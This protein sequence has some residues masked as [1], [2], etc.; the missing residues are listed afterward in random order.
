MITRIRHWFPPGIRLQLAVCY[1]TAFA[2]VLL[3]T[4]A[5]FYQYLESSLEASLDTDL[6]LRTQQ[7]AS[8]IVIRN[9]TLMVH[10]VAGDL[11]G[12][13]SATN[14]QPVDVNYGTLIRLLNVHGTP[15]SQTPAF[16]TLRVPARSVRQPL[17]GKPWQGTVLSAKGQEVRLY[18]RT[19]SERGRTVALLQVGESLTHLHALLHELVEA[20]LIVGSLVLLACAGGSYWLTARAFAP[21]LRLAETAR[22]IKAGDL[23]QRVPVPRAHDEIHALAVTLNDMLASLDQAFKDQRRFVADASHELRTPV[24]VIR[25]KAGITLLGTPTLPEAI[26]VLQEIGAETE[27]LSHLISDLLALARG[28][29]GEAQFERELVRLDLLVEA[30]TA[31]AEWLAA[32]R[33]ITLTVQTGE[34]VTLQGDEARLIQVVMNLLDNALRYTHPGGQVAVIVEACQTE[35]RLIAR[36]TGIGIAPEDLPHIF[37]RF[38]RADGARM[39]TGS[40]S[41]GLGLSIVEWIVRVHGGLIT[42]ESQVGQGSCFTVTLPLVQLT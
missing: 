3:V 26:T 31:N 1:I 11:P 30:V 37:E 29:E 38:Y 34:P 41:S 40:S 23:D 35:A 12:F 13:D 22:R 19:L 32:E 4:G 8:D 5:V 21:I 36:D 14:D 27:R 18:S 2:I 7:V 42:V 24:T 9:G 25:N 20:L 39:R 28:D 16:R 10:A 6:Q 15:L 33:G 17:Q